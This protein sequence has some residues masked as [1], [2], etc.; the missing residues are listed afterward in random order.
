MAKKPGLKAR[1]ASVKAAMSVAHDEPEKPTGKTV[2]ASLRLDP[3]RHEVLRT[4][5]FNTRR[6][7]HSLLL[8]GVDEVVKKYDQ[9]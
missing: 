5:A 9:K 3:E 1:S 2:A 8:E 6:S 7:L 4:I